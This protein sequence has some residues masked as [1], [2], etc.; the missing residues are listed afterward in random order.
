MTPLHV[1]A[2]GGGA[3]RS[4]TWARLVFFSLSVTVASI[5]STAVWI[6]S[7]WASIS[8][9]MSAIFIFTLMGGFCCGCV[10]SSPIVY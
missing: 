1:S 4:A 9:S 2:L 10:N 7:L 5:L 6:W 8:N 3:G